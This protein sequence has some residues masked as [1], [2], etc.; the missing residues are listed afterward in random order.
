MGKIVS[1]RRSV[2]LEEKDRTASEAVVGVN[3]FG[4][5][6]IVERVA[7]FFTRAS[8][9]RKPDAARSCILGY[10]ILSNQPVYVKFDISWL[11]AQPC[12]GPVPGNYGTVD[13]TDFTLMPRA[14][15][16]EPER[17]IVNLH[18]R[19][20]VGIAN[21]RGEASAVGRSQLDAPV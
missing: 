7:G 6:L 13:T 10:R 16:S 9:I 17:E 15:S 14:S 20:R 3:S 2:V 1:Y 5:K 4:A 18:V 12:F 19:A 8:I 11:K 21:S